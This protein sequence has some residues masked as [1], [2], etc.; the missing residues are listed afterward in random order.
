MKLYQNKALG[1]EIN[2]PDHWPN[3]VIPAPDTA[4]FNIAPDE[5][6]N[7]IVGPLVPERLVEFTQVEFLQYAKS[8]GYTDVEIGVIPV[9]SRDHAWGRYSM[10]NGTWSK[11]Y[12]L[13]FGTMEYAIT[14]SCLGKSLIPEKEKQWDG[15]VGSFRL[16]EWRRQEVNARNEY[17]SN[18][19]GKLFEKAYEAASE[20][21][22]QEACILLEECLKENPNHTLAHK[23]LAFILKNTG[24]IKGALLHRRIVK[25]L[26]PADQ[27]NRYNLA[28]IYTILGSKGEAIQEM[29]DLLA[30]NPHDQ[31][32][33]ET[34]KS[35]E[36]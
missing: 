18:V 4:V 20:G 1:F 2:I 33:I 31:R 24:D 28:M 15:I 29:D 13:A 27:V 34:R 30:Q 16:L 8:K 21:R 3:P 10:G 9:E 6:F 14:A 25:H 12:M 26:D 19:A 36:K 32:Y 11:K 23:E 5:R 7:I 35:F 22:Y 17:R